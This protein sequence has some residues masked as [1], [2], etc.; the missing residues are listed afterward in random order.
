G[1]YPYKRD[2]KN[3]DFNILNT[4]HFALEEDLYVITNHIDNF[5]QKN[6]A[7]KATDK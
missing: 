4:G 1:A 7:N 6:V 3:V 5:M 2:L